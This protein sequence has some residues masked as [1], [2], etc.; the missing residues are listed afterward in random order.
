MR[1]PMIG[2]PPASR[3]R[4]AKSLL[5]ACL[6]L[7]AGVLIKLDAAGMIAANV[8]SRVS[9]LSTPVMQVMQKPSSYAEYRQQ[10]AAD[11]ATEPSRAGQPSRGSALMDPPNRPHGPGGPQNRPAPQQN[12][13]AAPPQSRPGTQPYGAPGA[14]G[15]QQFGG[16]GAPTQ[17]RPGTQQFGAPG[18]PPQ[19]RPGTQPYGAPGA[20]GTQQ[21][22]GPGAPTQNRPGTQQFGAPGAPPQNRPG[23][24][25]YGAPGAPGTQ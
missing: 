20:P 22:G 9:R 13:P 8:L 6:L 19:N 23:T 3:C 18:A 21:F 24:Q 17:N 1:T 7:G 4:V 16:P 25:P 10:Y 14:P 15:T 5:A 11:S 2:T 12:G